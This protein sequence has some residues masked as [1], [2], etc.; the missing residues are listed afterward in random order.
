MPT[1]VFTIKVCVISVS[2]QVTVKGVIGGSVVLPC[3]ST[4]HDLK[5]QDTYVHW[6]DKNDKIV[7]SVLKGKDSVAGQDQWYKNRAETFP[8]EYLRIN[9]SIKLSG[10]THADAGEYI[11]Y[12]TPSNEQETVLLIIKGV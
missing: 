11:C 6:R 7:H 5:L 4:E 1:S 2:L 12:I 10:L 9:F 8:D 3:S